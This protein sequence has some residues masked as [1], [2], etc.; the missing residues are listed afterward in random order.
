MSTSV[1]ARGRIVMAQKEGRAIPPGWAIDEEG[2]PTEDPA[3]AL[4]GAV[5]PMAGYKGAGLAL[6]IDVLC[7]VLT[8]AAFGRHIVDLYDEGNRHQN[9]GHF[10]IA[11]AVEA[12]M[13]VP[14]FTGRLRQFAAEVRAQPRLPDVE[15]IYVP[16]EI[17]FAAADKAAHTGVAVSEAGWTEL[18]DL[19]RKLNV[20]PLD[21]RLRESE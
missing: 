3:T 7:G 11:I 4:R 16:G 15:R 21:E 17:E 5:L 12:F 9:V 18:R 1:V 8:G 13:P 6:M 20:A 19:A 10:F 2:I 14:A